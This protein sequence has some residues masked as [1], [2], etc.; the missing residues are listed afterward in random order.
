VAHDL[1]GVESVERLPVPRA[2]A[3]DHGPAE[4]RLRALEDQELEQLPVV[5]E[6]HPPLSVMIADLQPA[7]GPLAPPH[8]SPPPAIR[9]RRRPR[10]VARPAARVNPRVRPWRPG[11]ALPMMTGSSPASTGGRPHEFGAPGRP[12]TRP[13]EFPAGAFR[14][15]DEED[16][17]VFYASARRVVHLDAPALAVLTRVYGSLVPSTGCVLDLMASWRS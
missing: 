11:A 7:S 5:V 3:Q 4:A 2:A 10:M 8:A 6:R 17:R 12:M 15:A 14:R 1:R 16:D 13:F 9:R